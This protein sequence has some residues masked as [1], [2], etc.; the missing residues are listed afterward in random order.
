MKPEANAIEVF[1]DIW[2]PFAHVGLRTVVAER[3]SRGRNDMPLIVR[4]W[5]LEL[6][7]NAPMNPAKTTD[8]VHHLREQLVP[9]LFA[10]FDPQNFPHS[11]LPALALVWRAYRVSNNLGEIASLAVR[12]ELFEHGRN[13]A[14]PSVL[15]DLGARLGIPDVDRSGTGSD[16]RGVLD[17]WEEGK[18]RGVIGSPHFFCG[19]LSVFCPSLQI[20]RTEAGGPEIEFDPGKLHA[21]LD[22]TLSP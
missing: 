5:P 22:A 1:A 10:N 20:T 21:F 18:R 4:A 19:E 2:C 16:Q 7:N 6:V 15:S 3:A 11:T 17:D 13:I 8:H 12:D 14:D 9:D